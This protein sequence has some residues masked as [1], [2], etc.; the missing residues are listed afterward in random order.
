MLASTGWP[1][2]TVE[3]SAASLPR[4]ILDRMIGSSDVCSGTWREWQK[5]LNQEPARSSLRHRPPV[6]VRARVQRAGVGEVGDSPLPDRSRP[7]PVR[8][9]W[10]RRGARAVPCIQRL[11]C[12]LMH[13]ITLVADR[14]SFAARSATVRSVRLTAN[15]MSSWLHGRHRFAAR[16]L[17]LGPA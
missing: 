16:S 10:P 11:E 15:S 8:T 4:S 1:R 12:F 6:P 14:P 3:P 5:I 2:F 17:F 7:S 9:N 13:S